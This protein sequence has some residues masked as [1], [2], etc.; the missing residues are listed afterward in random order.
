MHLL[1]SQPVA[2]IHSSSLI[3][4]ATAGR[5]RATLRSVLPPPPALIH[6]SPCTVLPHGMQLPSFASATLD[7]RPFPTAWALGIGDAKMIHLVRHGEGDHNVAASLYGAQAYAMTSLL[8]A[9]LNAT[10]IEQARGLG[11]RIRGRGLAVEVVIVSPLRRALRTAVEMFPPALDPPPIVANELCREAA[12]LHCCDE[13]RPIS[14]AALEFSGVNFRGCLNDADVLHNPTRRETVRE[15]AL[16]ADLFIDV[17]RA[18]PERHIAVVSHGV[19]LESLMTRCSLCVPEDALR[20][21]HFANAEMRS[22]VV[23]AW[24]PLPPAPALSLANLVVR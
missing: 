16:R 1:T 7:L 5:P 19:F 17:L 6:T 20:R 3:S 22:I 9:D 18:R 15:V 2:F 10:G 23:G 21:G 13:R 14:V 24:R 12:G 11:E 8:D 4:V